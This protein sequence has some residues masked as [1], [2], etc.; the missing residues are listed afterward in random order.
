MAMTSLVEEYRAQSA[1]VEAAGTLYSEAQVRL[2]FVDKMLRIFGWDVDNDD[3]KQQGARDVV[4]EL[5]LG[6]E[7][8]TGRPDYRLRVDGRDR[9]P[10]EAKKPSVRLAASPASATQARSYGFTLQRPAAVLTNFSELVLYDTSIEPAQGDG[11]DVA[12]IPNCR[13]GWQEYVSR[14]DE[15]WQRISF[16]Y[17][18]SDRFYE[19]YQYT[20]PPRGQSPF[21]ITFLAHFRAWRLVLAQSIADRNSHL[22]PAEVG[23]RTQRLLNA[24]LFIRVC[25]DRNIGR[26][27]DL[28]A[29]AEDS[30]ILE[31]FER[32]DKVFNA[33]LFSVLRDTTVSAADLRAVVKEMYWPQ[34]KFAYAL[35]QAGTLSAVYEQYLAERVAADPSGKVWLEPKP[36]LTHSGGV[37]PTPL[38]VV[39]NL[40]DACLGRELRAGAAPSQ[41]LTVLD[42]ACGSGVFLVEALAR[43]ISAAEAADEVVDLRRRATLAVQHLFGVDVDGEA[44]EVA[45]LSIL[46]SVLGDD[47][48]DVRT[49]SDVLPDLAKNLRV[50]NSLIGPDFDTLLADQAA[51]PEVRADVAPFDWNAAFPSELTSGGFTCIVGN[52]PYVRIQVLADHLPVQL[53]YFQHPRVRYV[54]AQGSFDEYMLFME[55]A[56]ELLAADGTLALIVKSTLVTSPSAAPLRE[57][58]GQKIIKLVHFGSQQI[59]PGRQTYACLLIASG[60]D[61]SDPV[62]LQL[63]HD[64]DAWR[65]GLGGA[66][67]SLAERDQ[68]IGAPWVMAS[69]AAAAVYAKMDSVAVAHLG[70]PGWVSIFVGVQTSA[71]DVFYLKLVDDDKISPLIKVADRNGKVWAVERD[72]S[73]PAIRDRQLTPYG[74]EPESDF[75]ALFPYDLEAAGPGRVRGKAT[76][77]SEAALTSRYPQ[78][79]KYFQANETRLRA[80][81]ISPDPGPAYWAYGRSQNLTKMDGPKIINRTLSVTPQYVPDGRGFIVPGGGD[82]GP[83]TLL[84]AAPSCPLTPEVVIALLSHP[85][86]DAYIAARSKEYRG[87]YVVHRKATLKPVPVPP[88][89]SS[90][91]IEITSKIQEMQRA[92]LRLRTEADGKI[93]VSLRDRRSAL[94]EQ[95]NDVILNAYGLTAH[96]LASLQE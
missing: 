91:I 44:V 37:V 87:A 40:L 33:G 12:V 19:I 75:I 36:E 72:I 22:T 71:D 54:S 9:L 96:D 8:S 34:S 90:Q 24:L 84:R 18:S 67:T 78:A 27:K 21:D 70:D 32:A 39:E 74:A 62:Q 93:A 15:L 42:P 5:T 45:K 52:P 53:R 58:L 35:L 86:V 61:Q 48:V 73:R 49:E 6:E 28:L 89:A 25:E 57:L 47:F 82:G 38:D 41:N 65:K 51:I 81:S 50:G 83:Y 95:V 88:L 56:I 23:R 43:L 17:V 60:Q 7:G 80:R 77:L 11:A 69:A 1:S 66:I 4:V 10:V 64:L 85:L 94:A 55:K 13:F 20:E 29:A 76:L 30:K 68:F 14:F 59:F 26:Y 2:D 16:E 63:V 3:S 79:L 31:E 46:L 92:E